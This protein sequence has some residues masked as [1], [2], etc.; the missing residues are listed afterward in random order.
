[1]PRAGDTVRLHGG[2]LV[3]TQDAGLLA[4]QLDRT[5]TLTPAALVS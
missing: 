1:L 2:I 3:L 4:A 5:A